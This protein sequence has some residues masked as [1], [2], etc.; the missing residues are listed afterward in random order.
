MRALLQYALK[1]GQAYHPQAPPK[2]LR[3]LV[4]GLSAAGRRFS[5]ARSCRDV[6]GVL[7]RVVVVEAISTLLPGSATA[8][9]R[10]GGGAQD[11]DGQDSLGEAASARRASRPRRPGEQRLDG[12]TLSWRPHGLP[13]RDP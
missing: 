3:G 6:L 8:I 4:G 12:P 13:T 7:A 2:A 5:C 1:S 9:L 11:H 10:V